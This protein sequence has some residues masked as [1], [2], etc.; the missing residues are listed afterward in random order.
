MVVQPI[1]QLTNKDIRLYQMQRRQC[2]SNTNGKASFLKNG[3]REDLLEEMSYEQTANDE[4][5][6][7]KK[8]FR[9]Y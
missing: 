7:E 5:E 6:N 2:K 8:H 3:D 4:K 1:R 9:S